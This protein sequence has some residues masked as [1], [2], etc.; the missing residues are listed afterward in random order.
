[1]PCV[2]L[3]AE[4]RLSPPSPLHL[5]SPD[6]ET[7]SPA[8]HSPHTHI[9]LAFHAPPLSPPTPPLPPPT[10]SSKV[11]HAI[12][13]W[14]VGVCVSQIVWSIAFAQEIQWLALT[15]MWGILLCL[16]MIAYRV[17]QLRDSTYLE[18]VIL[19]GP[20]FLQLGW[21]CAASLVNLNVVIDAAIPTILPNVTASILK[22]GTIVDAAG[23]ALTPAQA[24]NPAYFA[25]SNATL[26]LAAAVL[27]LAALFL[28]GVVVGT[29]P[30]R[31]NGNVIVCGVVAW[32]L[33]G[34]A[35]QL[36]EPAFK[37]TR[38]FAPT[39]DTM[40]IDAL[41]DAAAFL[42]VAM[43]LLVAYLVAKLV[44]DE[45]K[46]RPAGGIGGSP[47]NAMKKSLSQNDGLKNPAGDMETG[48]A[49]AGGEGGSSPIRA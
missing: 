49:A 33:G 31:V 23:H 10:S 32:A 4:H 47:A 1:M 25:Q 27:S 12:H 26:L 8:S 6:R 16:G 43:L 21:I 30:D 41:A 5:P 2:S 13:Y 46:A 35:A 40:I 24:L 28:V 36:R 39:G 48:G 19:K 44:F 3:L 17:S 34:V 20:F 11:F 45:W 18:F 7:L 38:M 37:T 42:S 9:T 29:F 22:N 14:W 15:C